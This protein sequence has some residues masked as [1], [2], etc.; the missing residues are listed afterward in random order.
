[1]YSARVERAWAESKTLHGLALAAD[2]VERHHQRP[3]QYLRVRLGGAEKPFALASE[4]GAARLELLFKADT[5]LTSAMGRL[6]PGDDLPVGLPQGAGFPVDEHQGQDL[7]LVAAG[8]GIAPLRAVV[9]TVLPH[10]R[11]FGQ[12][13]LFYGQRAES[14]FA[15]AEE[16]GAWRAAGIELHLVASEAGKRLQEA[17]RARHPETRKAAAYLCGMKGMIADVAH[18]LGDLGLPRERVFV[19]A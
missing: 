7:I 11:R 9:R 6:A 4:P 1:M 12:I 19:N 16:H 10:R 17:V 15:Y 18:I 2:E 8:T 13:L 3:G 14:H 5:E